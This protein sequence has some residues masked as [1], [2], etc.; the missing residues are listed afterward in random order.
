M[1]SKFGQFVE[2]YREDTRA[3]SDY[4]RQSVSLRFGRDGTTRS[5]QVCSAF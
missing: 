4:E 3:G 5:A 1:V 2:T